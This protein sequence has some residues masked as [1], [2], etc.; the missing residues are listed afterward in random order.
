MSTS[1][2]ITASLFEPSFSSAGGRGLLL[3]I[4]LS[5]DDLRFLSAFLSDEEEDLSSVVLLFE[6]DEGFV[7]V[8]LLSEDDC[9]EDGVSLSVTLLSEDS[10][11]IASSTR[12][13]SASTSTMSPATMSLLEILFVFVVRS[14]P[15]RASN[16]CLNE[17]G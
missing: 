6:D 15:S 8:A 9:T 12:E 11:T 5:E 4:L 13:R 17:K 16:T 3:V 14:Y 1:L 10:G 7:S 2:N